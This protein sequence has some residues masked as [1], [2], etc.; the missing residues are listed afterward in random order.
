MANNRIYYACQQVLIKTPNGYYYPIRGLQSVGVT[1]NFNLTQVFEIGQLSIYEN[2]E[3]IPDVQITLN[4]VLDGYTPIYTMA[5]AGSDYPTLASRCL[6]TCSVNLSVFN[7]AT[8]SAVGTPIGRMESSG[9]YV[10]SVRYQFPRDGNFSEEVSLVGNNKV[11]QADSRITTN[12]ASYAWANGLA[13]TG[14]FAGNDA[15]SA[16]GGIARRQNIILGVSTSG[17]SDNNGYVLDADRTILPTIVAGVDSTGCVNLDDSERAHL[18]SISVS[19]NINRESINELG[20][21]GPYFRT[22]TFPIEVTTEIEITATSGDMVSAT[23]SGILSAADASA[24]SDAGNLGDSTIRI[25][26]CEGLRVYCGLKNKLSS[27]N[28]GGG[29][30]G[31]GQV[32]VSYTFQTFNDFT[33]VHSGDAL[34]TSDACASTGFWLTGIAYL[35]N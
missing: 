33:V 27:V 10:S 28:Y 4:K 9:M 14:Y 19:C 5:T 23:E 2:I 8:D 31:G 34:M 22:P 1:T 26:T 21:K 11:W 12:N 32:A 20:R 24:C 13:N 7:E 25:A 30:A 29:D 3:E 18:N 15:P 16:A 6:K 35:I 17:D